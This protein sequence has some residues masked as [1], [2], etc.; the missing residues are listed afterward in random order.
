MQTNK[1]RRRDKVSHARSS[2]TD[3]HRETETSSSGDEKLDTIFTTENQTKPPA[4]IEMVTHSAVEKHRSKSLED[5]S[6]GLKSIGELNSTSSS[7]NLTRILQERSK[8]YVTGIRKG[9]TAE[10]KSQTIEVHVHGSM[11]Q[12]CDQIKNSRFRSSRSD[13]IVPIDI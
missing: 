10:R 9:N 6:R 4:V 13:P 7:R 12:D 1:R 3:F 8:K 11:S 5:L 2:S